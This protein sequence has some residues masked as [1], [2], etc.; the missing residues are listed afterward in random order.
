MKY[1]ISL[2]ILSFSACSLLGLADEDVTARSRANVVIVKNGTKERVY[3]F[4]VGRQLAAR[5]N[6]AQSLDPGNSVAAG[7]SRA[8]SHEEIS[9][10]EGGEDEA[11]VYWWHAEGQGE[12]LKP[13]ELNSI[14]VELE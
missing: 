6:W 8:I 5:I 7:D 10:E 2:L 3:Y 1:I 9:Q 11:V 13:G 14:V 12:T 4:V